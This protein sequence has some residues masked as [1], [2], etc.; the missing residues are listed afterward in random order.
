MSAGRELCYGL[1][2]SRHPA[3]RG[4]QSVGLISTPIKMTFHA[5]RG[6]WSQANKGKTACN[7][8]VNTNKVQCYEHLCCRFPFQTALFAPFLFFFPPGCHLR[9]TVPSVYTCSVC[10]FFW[11]DLSL[12]LLQRC[13]DYFSYPLHRCYYRPRSGVKISV[14][15]APAHHPLGT[16]V[17]SMTCICQCDARIK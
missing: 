2:A 8:S 1:I 3:C 13:G 12:L 7:K 16:Y 9:I 5:A 6:I 14:I 15:A 4:S 10:E 11:V 17:V